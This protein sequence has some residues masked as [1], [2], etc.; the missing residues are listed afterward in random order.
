MSGDNSRH[1]FPAEALTPAG[2][3]LRQKDRRETGSPVWAFA[4]HLHRS[5]FDNGAVNFTS[6]A[7]SRRRLVIRIA[8]NFTADSMRNARV[9]HSIVTRIV[10]AVISIPLFESSTYRIPVCAQIPVFT[11]TPGTCTVPVR[12]NCPS[13][14][15]T[16]AVLQWHIALG[17]QMPK[18]YTAGCL[19]TSTQPS[20]ARIFSSAVFIVSVV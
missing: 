8:V 11:S 9:I 20:E 2:I 7:A 15:R 4:A 19:K 6:L 5:Y 1:G 18:A 13:L 3:D 17:L 14:R 16:G 10:T 12:E